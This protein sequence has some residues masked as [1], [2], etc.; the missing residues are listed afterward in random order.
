MYKFTIPCYNCER[1]IDQCVNSVLSQKNTNW[2]AVIVDDGST[3]KTPEML[4]RYKNISQIKVVRFEKNRGSAIGSI[5]EATN[6]MSMN[7]D[8][9]IINLDGDDMLS[10]QNVLSYLDQVYADKNILMSY[11]QY[12]P[13]THGYH[14]FCQPLHNS[15][16]Y[17]KSGAWV[18]SHMRTYKKKLW[19]H[20]KDSDLRDDDGEYYRMAGDA[21]L[22]FPLIEL[23]GLHRIKFVSQ[24]LYLYNDMTEM[25]DMKRNPGLQ[26]GIANK[27]RA[28]SEYQE[29]GSII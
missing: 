14:N 16:T 6:N 4:E 17:R 12:E 25:N 2:E 10:D 15:R 18:V 8:D 27:I 26:V 19:N 29:L 28:K 24:V 5:V 21:A 23:S 22:I 9:V 13:M 20:I 11:G 3:D 1:W 7:P